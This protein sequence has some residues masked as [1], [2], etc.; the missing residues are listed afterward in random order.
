MKIVKVKIDAVIQDDRNAR[1]GDTAA[2]AASL[3][4][5]G[6]HRALV[7]QKSTNRIIVGNHMHRMCLLD[8]RYDFNTGNTFTKLGGCATIRTMDTERRDN[9]ILR[10]TFGDEVFPKKKRTP[11]AKGINGHEEQRTLNLPF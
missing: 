11:F 5:F 2:L 1:R 7:V 10:A 9:E 8:Y 6:Q 4:K 3:T